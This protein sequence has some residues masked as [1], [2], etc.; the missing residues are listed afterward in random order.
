[1]R[2][3]HNQV[4]LPGSGRFENA[5]MWMSVLDFDAFGGDACPLCNLA[6]PSQ[7]SGGAR[8]HVFKGILPD[9]FGRPSECIVI[10]A[11]ACQ[12][13]QDYD[14]SQ[15]RI[16]RRRKFDTRADSVFSDSRTISSH[17]NVSKY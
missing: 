1:M 13:C 11:D 3:H 4:D 17:Q 7:V 12:R 6:C 15:P 5:F 2:R 9:G 14:K 8:P 16:Q 10:I